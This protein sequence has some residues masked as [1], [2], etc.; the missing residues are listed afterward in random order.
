M[1]RASAK[2]STA[3]A[4]V[5]GIM[6]DD[7]EEDD[8][9]EEEE[10]DGAAAADETEMRRGWFDDDDDGVTLWDFCVCVC[11]GPSRVC[12]GVEVA[13][14]NVGDV[15]DDDD[16]VDEE[17]EDEADEEEVGDVERDGEV[18]DDDDVAVRELSERKSF[19]DCDLKRFE[20]R[21]KLPLPN[22]SPAF[23]CSAQ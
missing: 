21:R 22:M 19:D 8:D 10:E 12:V 4:V 5:D 6:L 17:E 15:K 20:R 13:A 14:W 23:G 2:P 16:V 7:E 3:V 9:D 18:R 11:N 1:N